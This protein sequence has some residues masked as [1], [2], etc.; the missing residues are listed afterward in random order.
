MLIWLVVGDSV[1][2]KALHHS[3]AD[4]APEGGF[5]HSWEQQI[6]TLP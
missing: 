1:Q 3:V 2:T 5:P 6:R 4:A